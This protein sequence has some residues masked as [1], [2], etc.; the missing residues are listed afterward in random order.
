LSDDQL[1]DVTRAASLLPPQQRDRFLRSIANRLSDFAGGGLSD[2]ELGQAISFVLGCYGAT[3]PF[4][5]RQLADQLDVVEQIDAG[6]VNE[7][8]QVDVELALRLGARRWS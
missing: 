1:A 8:Q 6:G 4:Q 7:G 2:Y 5:S 3:R